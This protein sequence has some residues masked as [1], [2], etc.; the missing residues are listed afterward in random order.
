MPAP[1]AQPRSPSGYLVF[2]FVEL[3]R[4]VRLLGAKS[5]KQLRLFSAIWR[6]RLHRCWRFMVA[7]ISSCSCLIWLCSCIPADL[8]VRERG[9]GDLPR[10]VADI[11]DVGVCDGLRGPLRLCRV[12]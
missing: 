7:A 1:A 9:G 3:Q 11:A 8:E 10:S 12:G 4:N 2:H 6:V 5:C